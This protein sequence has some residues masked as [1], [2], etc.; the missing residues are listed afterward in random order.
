MAETTKKNRPAGTLGHLSVHVEGSHPEEVPFLFEAQ[1]RRLPG[2]FAFSLAG[3]LV[4]VLF[5]LLF[6]HYAPERVYP[7][8]QLLPPES[9]EQIVWLIE[10]GPGGGGGGGG[11][12]MPEPPRKMEMPGTDKIS[13]PAV[14]PEPINLNNPEPTDKPEP[15]E[16]Q[17]LIPARTLSSGTQTLPG[18]IEGTSTA[19][20]SQGPGKGGGAGTGEG[21]GIGPGSGS[22]L[23]PGTGGGFGGGAYRPGSGVE[24]PVLVREVKP[25]YTAEAMRAKVQGKVVL[26]CVV[27]PD[28]TIG[29]AQV[30]RSLDPVF[31][32][33]EEALKA[34]RQWRFV[35]GTRLGEPV[36]VLISIEMDFTLR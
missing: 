22:G 34:A 30:I 15:P 6:I 24:L 8:E 33:D 23:G 16:Q 5:V 31:G 19:G 25:Q 21:G 7:E 1:E 12:E 27:L 13:V 9:L 2:A 36:A 32:L 20:L 17:V 35:P 10:P 26:E 14:K 18:A 4:A 11:N 3:H 29:E 28:G